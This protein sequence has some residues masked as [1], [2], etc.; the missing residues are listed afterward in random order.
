MI[1]RYIARCCAPLTLAHKTKLDTVSCG[2]EE[3]AK[4][5]K[6]E[7][8]AYTKWQLR[9]VERRQRK[10]VVP[11]RAQRRREPR[12]PP[13]RGNSNKQATARTFNRRTQ[14]SEVSKAFKRNDENF[15]EA[16]RFF[17]VVDRLVP[18]NSRMVSSEAM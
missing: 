11:K 17:F 1:Y 4:K 18:W 6:L 8:G 10:R 5:S 3:T 12:R 16:R 13:R 14:V 15:K 7:K 9:K 2:H